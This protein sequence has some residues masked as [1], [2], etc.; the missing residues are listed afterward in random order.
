MIIPNM[1]N[2]LPLLELSGDESPFNARINNT[3]EIR[4]KIA[5]KLEF[6]IIYFFSYT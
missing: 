5:D 3:E 6:S 4:Y 2:M 1:P